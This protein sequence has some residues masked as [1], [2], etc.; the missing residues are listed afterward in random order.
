[1]RTYCVCVLRKKLCNYHS[2]CFCLSVLRKK[3]C[4]CLSVSFFASPPY[5]CFWMDKS[6]LCIYHHFL[7]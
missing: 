2:C 5:Q 3:L 1:M 4:N 6:D 7:F